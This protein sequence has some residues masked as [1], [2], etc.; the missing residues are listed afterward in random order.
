MKITKYDKTTSEVIRESAGYI[1]EVCGVSND[2]MQCMHDLSRTYVITRY[3]SRNLICGCASCHTKTTQDP[4]YHREVFIRIKGSEEVQLNRERAHSG[5]RLK[6]WEKDEIRKHWMNEI[7][8]MKQLRSDGVTGKI[9]LEVPE[10]L[11]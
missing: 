4:H 5:D 10:I 9:E 11:L 3:D 7:K 8:R 2:T 6:P 1:C